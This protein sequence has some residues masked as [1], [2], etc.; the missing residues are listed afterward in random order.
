MK[1]KIILSMYAI[2]SI[3]NPSV[4]TC[5]SEDLKGFH[6]F[7]EETHQEFERSPLREIGSISIT[8]MDT[9]V[10]SSTEVLLPEDLKFNDEK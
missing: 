3:S 4:V 10:T 5:R 9:Y 2:F 6:Y 8:G 1:Y 7:H